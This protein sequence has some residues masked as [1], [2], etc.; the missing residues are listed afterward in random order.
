MPCVPELLEWGGV[1]C[2]M[3]HPHHPLIDLPESWARPGDPVR[4]VP[5][6]FGSWQNVADDYGLHPLHSNSVEGESVDCDVMEQCAKASEHVM[7]SL[8][9]VARLHNLAKRRSRLYT[10]YRF[11][12][13]ESMRVQ[14]C[15]GR[16]P[17]S[18]CFLIHFSYTSHT[19]HI[20]ATLMELHRPC[21]VL[22]VEQAS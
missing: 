10:L 3:A 4:D 17:V 12:A 15:R 9:L 11:V 13:M 16:K 20:L 6:R 5:R 18:I 19:I 21:F 2:V 7:I 14:S 8:Q 22:L 1:I